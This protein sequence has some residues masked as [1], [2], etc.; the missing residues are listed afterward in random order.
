MRQSVSSRLDSRLDGPAPRLRATAVSEAEVTEHFGAEL[1]AAR[2]TAFTPKRPDAAGA[3]ARHARLAAHWAPVRARLRA[4]L[5]PAAGLEMVLAR[6]GA[7]RLPEDL[8]WPRAFYRDAVRHAREI[9][10]R[11]TFLDLAADSG[12]F[13]DDDESP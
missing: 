10:D 9:R 12:M 11:Y 4:V 7:P 3:E 13:D 2:W 6:A 1:G 8:H 5:R